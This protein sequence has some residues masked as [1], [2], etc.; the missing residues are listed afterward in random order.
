[1]LQYHSLAW[2]AVAAPY[3][4]EDCSVARVDLLKSP[5]LTCASLQTLGCLGPEAS[6]ML[7]LFGN[8]AWFGGFGNLV[9]GFRLTLDT[10]FYALAA[11]KYLQSAAQVLR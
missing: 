10:L 5:C 6:S 11:R 2:E 4:V 3:D 9:S 1:M 7:V 8:S